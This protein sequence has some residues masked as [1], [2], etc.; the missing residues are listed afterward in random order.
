MASGITNHLGLC[1]IC[2]VDEGLNGLRSDRL[3][4]ILYVKGGNLADVAVI[5]LIEASSLNDGHRY[6]SILG[7]SL[8]DGQAGSASTDNLPD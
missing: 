6:C 1:D 3:V 2:P 7:Q 5:Q 4:E 8:G